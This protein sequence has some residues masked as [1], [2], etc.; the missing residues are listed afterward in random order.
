MYELDELKLDFIKIINF[1]LLHPEYENEIG[2]EFLK[3]LAPDLD[4]DLVALII[5][6]IFE[7]FDFDEDY[8]E[9]PV[10]ED[11]EKEIEKLVE[12]GALHYKSVKERRLLKKKQEL[13]KKLG[14]K[15]ESL[16]FKRNYYFDK[17]KRR[18]VKRKK[19][20]DYKTLRKKAKIMKKL[21]KKSEFKNRI[22]RAK[23]HYKHL[24]V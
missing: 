15:A 1:L 3:I 6:D 17:K 13:K 21:H 19:P 23:E 20:L 22:K 16:E 14:K 7:Y 10:S 18:F 8:L 24:G 11:I 5:N 9:L 2:L 4:D 12:S